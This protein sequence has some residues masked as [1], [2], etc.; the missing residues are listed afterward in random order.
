MII[1]V[2]FGPL[3]KK[4]SDIRPDVQ[5]TTITFSPHGKISLP[6]EELVKVYGTIV[7][8]CKKMFGPEHWPESTGAAWNWVPSFC[9]GIDGNLEKIDIIVR[10][11]VCWL[12]FAQRWFPEQYASE[13]QFDDFSNVADAEPVEF[14]VGYQVREEAY[15]WCFDQFGQPDGVRWECN[16]YHYGGGGTWETSHSSSHG[17]VSFANKNDAT[18][19]A[20]RWI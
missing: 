5:G 14:Y 16:K 9:R 15:Q 10:S 18:L 6:P 2:N 17:I 8:W 20:L 1:R 11:P 13:F 4:Y 7:P 3:A 19:F 12:I